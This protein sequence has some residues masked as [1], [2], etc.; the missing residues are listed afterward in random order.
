M[1]I[2]DDLIA[3]KIKLI[4]RLRTNNTCPLYLLLASVHA[5]VSCIRAD[6]I[7]TRALPF[8]TMPLS[9]SALSL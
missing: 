4:R 5:S 9:Q 2:E 7:Q 8:L 1:K 3:S 6:L